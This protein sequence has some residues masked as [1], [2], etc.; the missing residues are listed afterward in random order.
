MHNVSRLFVSVGKPYIAI[1]DE[2]YAKLLHLSQWC[3][4]DGY[5]KRSGGRQ[6]TLSRVIANAKKGERVDHINGNT[7]DNRFL[8]LIIANPSENAMNMRKSGIKGVH[9]RSDVKKWRAGIKKNY[10][11]IW[12]GY[13]DTKREAALAYNKAAEE[14]FGCFACLNDVKSL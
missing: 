5:I 13:F 1:V 10:K 14:L 12:L 4:S 3:I 6:G 7:L 2:E 11:Q 9:Y 8:N